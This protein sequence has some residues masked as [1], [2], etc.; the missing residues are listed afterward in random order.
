MITSIEMKVPKKVI[1]KKFIPKTVVPKK[2]VPKKVTFNSNSKIQIPK[3]GKFM[4]IDKSKIFPCVSHIK[5]RTSP[6]PK[7]V[8]VPKFL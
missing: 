6:G 4:W 8:W 5:S 7:Q 1:Q 2:I 3:K